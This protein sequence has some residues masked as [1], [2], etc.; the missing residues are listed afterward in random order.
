MHPFYDL[1]KVPDILSQ[2]NVT[3]KLDQYKNDRSQI[4]F[5]FSFVKTVLRLLNRVRGG[6]IVG[7]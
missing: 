7:V 2:M 5:V 3:K 4:P 1:N 6:H